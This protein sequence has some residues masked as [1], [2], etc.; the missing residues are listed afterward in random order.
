MR[1]WKWLSPSVHA[2][3]FALAVT[4]S[5]SAS[6]QAPP[7][8]KTTTPA[9]ADEHWEERKA[10]AREDVEYCGVYLAAKQAENRAAELRVAVSVTYK[11][12][13]DRQKDKGYASPLQMKLGEISL[14]ESQSQLA[15]RRVELKDAEIRLARA[16]RRLLAV[17]RSGASVDPE[18]QDAADALRRL[19]IKYERLRTEFEEVKRTVD[20]QKTRP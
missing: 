5:S 18:P 10:R 14:A 13:M 1:T 15:T 12:E 8:P 7:D 4:A 2:T 17:E 11:A 3:A 6:P 16:R 19:E 20:S 9:I